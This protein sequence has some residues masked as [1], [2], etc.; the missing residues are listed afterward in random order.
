MSQEISL[1]KIS[2]QNYISQKVYEVSVNTL[3]G[4]WWVTKETVKQ[5]ILLGVPILIT[6]SIAKNTDLLDHNVYLS[7]RTINVKSVTN[8]S[9][10]YT[11]T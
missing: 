6:L 8:D 11:Y 5:T 2:L 7:N 3:D 10:T 4:L 1:Q 9:Y